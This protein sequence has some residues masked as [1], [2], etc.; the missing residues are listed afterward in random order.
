MT[1]G[2]IYVYRHNLQYKM[3]YSH[4]L[5]SYCHVQVLRQK[6]GKYGVGGVCNGGGGASALVVELV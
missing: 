6:N 4:Q 2:N 3:V 5:L 1:N